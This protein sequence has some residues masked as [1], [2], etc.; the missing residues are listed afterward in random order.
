MS[1]DRHRCKV[2]LGELTA[3]EFEVIHEMAVTT[4]QEKKTLTHT[5]CATV[6]LPS[7]PFEDGAYIR[8]RFAVTLLTSKFESD[9]IHA[10]S[11]HSR[12]SL[13]T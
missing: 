4:T 12:R 3:M 13:A 1:Y 9:S 8:L 10:H 2:A 5:P 6:K 11:P 7:T